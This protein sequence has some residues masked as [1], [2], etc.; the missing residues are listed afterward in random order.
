[1]NYR[2]R[3]VQ[4][5]DLEAV[6][7]LA[8]ESHTGVSIPRDPLLIRNKIQISLE[9]FS[10]QC[11]EPG[12]ENYLFVM[13]ESE[14]RQVVGVSAIAAKTGIATPVFFYQ[15]EEI[16]TKNKAMAE[17]PN[18]VIALKP[19]IAHNWPTEIGSLFL[20]HAHRKEGLGKLLSLGRFLF[21]ADHLMRF[22]KTIYANMRGLILPNDIAPFWEAIGRHFCDI[23]FLTL[24]DRIQA[25][26]SI[27]TSLAPTYP[28]YVN[29]LPEDVQNL[30]GSTHPSSTPAFNMLLKE[31]FAYINHIDPFDGGPIISSQ[32]RSIYT[33][34]NSLEGQLQTVLD[35]DFTADQYLIANRQLE[36]RAC[37]GKVLEY[38]DGKI[39]LPLAVVKNLEVKIG[40][41]IR[42][43]KSHHSGV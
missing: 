3:P 1:M 31:G 34:Q 32:T 40:D 33:V 25:D 10:K 11:K 19:I 27:L 5:N 16:P 23:N 42:Y 39:G 4:A 14:S 43:I 2:L 15:V 20:D 26:R 22:D 38:G 29:L 17:M 9:S 21:I 35:D 6:V 41:S 24:M 13:E 12:D 7:R 18:G 28:I 8:Q 36:F 37:L 30:I